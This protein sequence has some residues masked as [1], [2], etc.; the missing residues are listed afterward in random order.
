VPKRN[1]KSEGNPASE[2]ALVDPLPAPPLTLARAPSEL[3][4]LYEELGGPI[5]IMDGPAWPKF[6]GPC[7]EFSF[8]RLEVICRR[9]TDN[10]KEAFRHWPLMAFAASQYKF[11]RRQR[12][13]YSDE[14]TPSD[15]KIILARVKKAA[16][17][18]SSDLRKLREFATRLE[19]PSAPTRRPYLASIYFLLLQNMFGEPTARANP[20]PKVVIES[21]KRHDEFGDELTLLGTA[22]DIAL[23]Q[24]S[25]KYLSGGVRGQG[26]E[27]RGL[28]NLV[29]R[30]SK[31][32]KSLTGRAASVNKVAGGTPDFVRFVQQIANLA[33]GHKPTAAEIST[34][35]RTSKASGIK[36]ASGV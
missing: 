36:T 26:A 13:A 1:G 28:Y 24:F 18:L 11:E 33:T 22:V 12:A 7:A 30:S 32:W 19:N 17:S 29:W 5:P 10:D 3:D 35:L 8:V 16:S 34:A 9:W 20:D 2:Q 6:E 15:L 4:L 14:P 21:M 27:A 23:L 31:I 25:P